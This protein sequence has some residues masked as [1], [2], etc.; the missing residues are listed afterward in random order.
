MKTRSLPLI[1]VALGALVAFTGPATAAPSD[2]DPTFGSGG[3][4]NLP[5]LVNSSRFPS[6]TQPDGKIVLGYSSDSGPNDIAELMRITPSGAPDGSFGTGGVFALPLAGGANSYLAGVV[7]LPSGRILVGGTTSI[8]GTDRMIVWAVTPAGTLD[9]TFNAGLGYRLFPLIGTLA[10]YVT[11]FAVQA[12]GDIALVAEVESGG[13][14]GI[15]LQFVT[16]TG[17]VGGSTIKT[18]GSDVDPT[19]AAL[20]P[21]DAIVVGAIADNGGGTTVGLTT[22]FAASGAWDNLYNSTGVSVLG[23][24]VPIASAISSIATQ[25]DGLIYP[26]GHF[27][28]TGAIQVLNPDGTPN[29]EADP[30]GLT[31]LL[32]PNNASLFADAAFAAGGRVVT[33][34][35]TTNFFTINNAFVARF[36]RNGSIDSTFAA[37]ALPAIAPK[38]GGIS[39]IVQPDGHYL[40][41]TVDSDTRQLRV[42]RL[43]GDYVAPPVNTPLKT[44][45]GS[46]KSSQKA[47]KFKKFAGTASGTGLAKVG[48]AIQK[49]DSSLLKKSKKCT[50]VKNSSAATKRFKAVKG[51]CTPT[52]F[53]T[54]KGTTSWSF[55]LKKKLPPGKYKLFAR[56]TGAGGVKSSIISKSL[57]L[58]KK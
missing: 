36:N 12:D 49:I 21:G 50:F 41:F 14:S 17:G 20:Q 57:T 48:I 13:V 40:L 16:A 53:L 42:S 43:I 26:V 9:T 18:F 29:T 27:G 23:P 11:G 22:R 58:K 38:I 35:I 1:L 15:L 25:T 8:G 52:V 56:A 34:G 6:A 45:F 55:T 37:S 30:A 33:A 54:A 24:P 44:R 32:G 3:T 28:F 46:I 39:M 7:V 2:L 4:A 47:S 5:A 31:R 19:S 51:K 10:N